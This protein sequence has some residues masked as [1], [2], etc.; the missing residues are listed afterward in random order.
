MVY[1]YFLIVYFQQN[2]EGFKFI[3][4]LVYINI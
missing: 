1:Y 3:I 2:V 4:V